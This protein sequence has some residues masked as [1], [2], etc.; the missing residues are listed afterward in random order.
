MVVH[1]LNL[2]TLEQKQVDISEFKTC[3]AYKVS[4]Q[5]LKATWQ[6]PASK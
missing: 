5:P 4:S 6:N 1:I 2:N 3:L